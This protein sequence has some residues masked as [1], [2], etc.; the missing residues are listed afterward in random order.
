M[1][2]EVLKYRLAEL[3]MLVVQRD[4]PQQ[5]T[6]RLWSGSNPDFPYL[7]E[8]IPNLELLL[9]IIDPSLL[10]QGQEQDNIS[11][12]QVAEKVSDKTETPINEDQEEISQELLALAII[13]TN[14][15][16][17]L[18]DE[19]QKELLKEDLDHAIDEVF[20]SNENTISAMKTLYKD[21][22][23]INPEASPKEQEKL[24]KEKISNAKKSGLTE[25]QGKNLME[26]GIIKAKV[27]NVANNLAS[28]ILDP[29]LTNV[30]KETKGL[31]ENLINPRGD[32]NNFSLNEVILDPKGDDQIKRRENIDKNLSNINESLLKIQKNIKEKAENQ[33]PVIQ[34]YLLLS[35][36]KSDI[37]INQEIISDEEI[38][39]KIKQGL[40][41]IEDK[42][43]NIEDLKFKNFNLE[44]TPS[45]QRFNGLIDSIPNKIKINN[46]INDKEVNKTSVSQ[47]SKNEIENVQ[48]SI[49]REGYK[50]DNKID[51]KEL[52]DEEGPST[53]DEVETI[54][55]NKESDINILANKNKTEIKETNNTKISGGD[56]AE[57]EKEKITIDESKKS[58]NKKDRINIEPIL[59]NEVKSEIE[60]ISTT[61]SNMG[62]Q[63][64]DSQDYW[65][66]EDID[67]E[68]IINPINITK[69][70]K[71]TIENPIKETSINNDGKTSINH[72]D[73][74]SSNFEEV[75]NQE[76]ETILDNIFNIAKNWF[77]SF[78][79]DENSDKKDPL[80]DVSIA[81]SDNEAK[82]PSALP[83]EE[84]KG[85]GKSL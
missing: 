79:A 52:E 66:L 39:N 85:T 67:E 48:R 46:F 10:P 33:S 80:Q 37:N 64:N 49:T 77:A 75:E 31:I 55:D 11:A 40:K 60:T 34:S 20:A 14:I 38:S 32:M 44:L 62:V 83:S 7:K 72:Q 45:E 17:N 57:L 71:S 76:E 59:S 23:S 26:A 81:D 63:S 51:N 65:N 27:A 70:N 78:L 21:L 2:N 29:V 47:S 18:F 61:F 28:G 16:N 12:A 19:E 36:L 73:P 8:N 82:S 25:E 1:A 42:N 74:N 4:L 13:F 58:S 68:V 56:N 3:I 54:V 9:Q 15:F 43:I 69:M 50:A 53:F 24:V 22:T 84:N 5:A 35:I 6:E 30:L 41:S